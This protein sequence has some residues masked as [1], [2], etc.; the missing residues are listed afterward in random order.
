HD[1]GGPFDKERQRVFEAGTKLLLSPGASQVYY[2]DETARP[3]VVEGANGDANLRSFM[4]WEELS[5]NET[6]NGYT[7]NDVRQHWAK[8][9]RFRREHVAVGAGVHEKIAEEPYTFKRTY[10]G[11]GYD[12]KIVVALDY[13]GTE[14]IVSI[15]DVFDNGTVLKEYYT[16][17]N[18][19]VENGSVSISNA[20][21]VILL[22]KS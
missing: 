5:S 11:K 16:G 8:L 15:A 19:T 21:S 3:L 6:R 18:V 17:Q 9:G 14:V 7:V 12:D 13:E 20:G 1:D 4:N 10:S 2:G 22:G